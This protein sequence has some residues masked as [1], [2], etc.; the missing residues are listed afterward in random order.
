M[1]NPTR[2]SVDRRYANGLAK[3]CNRGRWDWERQSSSRD[4]KRVDRIRARRGGC[5]ALP[6]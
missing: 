3:V 6:G 2:G 1:K 4:G 5:E